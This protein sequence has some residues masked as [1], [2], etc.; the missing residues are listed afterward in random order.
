MNRIVRQSGWVG[1][2]LLA[3]ALV[4]QAAA[5]SSK[6]GVFD[7]QRVSEETAL[8]RQV[9]AD[10]GAFREQKQ[11]EISAKQDQLEELEK[12]LGQQSLSLSSE[13]R[14]QMERDIQRLRLDIQSLTETATRELQLELGAASDDFQRKL[15]AAV[16]SFGKDEGFSLLLDRSLVAWSAEAIDVTGA[17]VERFDRL[18]PGTAAPASGGSA[19]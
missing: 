14:S 19:E 5:Q 9:Q 4:P 6:I 10:I 15:L 18:F 8:G 7:P 16:E 11:S 2:V 12:Q 1:L 13:R 3:L 17:I